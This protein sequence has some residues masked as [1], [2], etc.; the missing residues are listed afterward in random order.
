MAD[1]SPRMLA[2]VAD[3]FKVLS[4]VSRLQILCELRTGGKNV[5]EIMQA[6]GMGQANLSK[7]LKVLTQ[8]GIVSRQPRGV[9]VFYEITDP[10]CLEICEIVCQQLI[11]QISQQYQQWQGIHSLGEAPQ[12]AL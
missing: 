7:H 10:V 11:A 8:A 1:L 4:E 3:Y 12:K 6:T 9:N 5:S 2:N